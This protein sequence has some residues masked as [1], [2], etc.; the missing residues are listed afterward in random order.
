M[1]TD[2]NLMA[3]ESEPNVVYFKDSFTD[4]SNVDTT[5]SSGAIVN[6]STSEGIATL[7]RT[8]ST[9]CESK[10]K[11]TVVAGNGDAGNYYVAKR[12]QVSTDDGSIVINAKYVS[13]DGAHDD[14][15]AIIDGRPDTWFEYQLVNISDADKAITKGYDIDW[16]R[17]KEYGDKLRLRIVIDLV[18][19]QDVN[20]I[21]INPYIPE[22]SNGRVYIYSIKTSA[23]GIDYDSVSD[24]TTILN[25]EISRISH[26][27]D[28][29]K[30]FVGNVYSNEKIASQGTFWFPPRKTRFIEIVMDQDQPYTDTVGHTYYEKVITKEGL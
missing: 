18:N 17:G 28:K 19:V 11:V 2:F 27:Y 20:W 8:K 26:T 4:Y 15:A 12:T 29:D 10:A 25:S 21:D 6:I 22:K 13:D 1:A 9:D 30:I 16:A 24:G 3:N 23:D 14:P 5:I 7:A